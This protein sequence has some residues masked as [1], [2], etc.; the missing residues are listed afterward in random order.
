MADWVEQRAEQEIKLQR[1]ARAFWDN[2]CSASEQAVKSYKHYYESTKI[3]PEFTRTADNAFR[4]HTITQPGKNDDIEVMFDQKRCMII[5]TRRDRSPVRYP[6]QISEDG[7]VVAL[8]DDNKELDFAQLSRILLEDLLFP[9]LH[10][11]SSQTK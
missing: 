11:L 5:A 3:S 1:E 8:G 2:L 6:L 10:V 4:V 9:K 7:R